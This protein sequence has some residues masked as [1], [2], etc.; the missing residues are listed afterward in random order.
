M[1]FRYFY[2]SNVCLAYGLILVSKLWPETGLLARATIENGFYEVAT[3]VTLLA[4]AIGLGW[5]WMTLSSSSWQLRLGCGAMALLCFIGAGEEISW[6]QHWLKFE[7]GEF[8]QSHNYQKETN[9]H[10]LVNPILFSTLINVVLYI[11]FILYPFTHWVFPNN[12]LSQLLIKYNLGAYIPPITIAILLMLA[13]CFHG[14]FIP[15]VYSDTAALLG[16]WSLGLVLM[17]IYKKRVNDP[18]LWIAMLVCGIGFAVGI[19]ASDIFQRDNF[20][21]EIRECFTALVLVYWAFGWS[22]LLEQIKP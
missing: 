9:L 14:W 4:G 17:L 5:R 20:Q 8:F 19:G 2:L 22:G 18:F 10:N 21:Y 16:S 6:G 12:R 13:H 7:S 11:G 15:Q 1:A 3:A